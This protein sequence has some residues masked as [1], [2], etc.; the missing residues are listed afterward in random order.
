MRH[1]RLVSTIGAR[2]QRVAALGVFIALGLAGGGLAISAASAA[3]GAPVFAAAIDPGLPTGPDVSATSQDATFYDVTCTS[4]GDCVAVG[5]YLDGNGSDDRQAMV[6]TETNGTWARPTGIPSLPSGAATGAGQQGAFLDG[7]TCASAGDCTAVGGY[8]DTTGSGQAMV[9][10]ETNGVWAAAKKLTLPSGYN[11]TADDQSAYLSAV[12]C[13]GAGNC[14]A[15]GS[16]YD[17]TGDS[18]DQQ[19]MIATET[20]GTWASAKLALPG[21]A[22]PGSDVFHAGLNT[23]TCSGPGDCVAGGYYLDSNGPNDYQAML[24]KDTG[25]TWTAAKLALPT[26]AVTTPSGQSA[27][28]NSITCTSAG[29]CVGGGYYEDADTPHPDYQAMV[30]S[31]TNGTWAQPTEVT[32]PA[33]HTTNG[34]EDAAVISVACTAPGDCVAVGSYYDNNG[35]YDGQP[36]YL[37]QTAGVWTSA[38][39]ASLPADALTTPGNQDGQFRAVACTGLGTCV[40]VGNYSNLHGEYQPMI[41][42]SLPSLAVSTTSLPAAGVGS[43]YSAQL[44]ASG[45]SGHYTWSVSAGTLP[46]GLTLNTA[47][48]VIS[49]TPT[50]L[51]TA[52]ITVLASDP[53][54]PAQQASAALSIAVDGPSIGTVKSEAPELKISIT[55]GAIAPQSCSGTLALSVSEHLTGDKITA[56]VAKAKHKKPKHTTRTV[57]IGK[58]NYSVSGGSAATVAVTLNKAGKQLLAKYHKLHAK[59]ADTPTGLATALTTQTVTITPH[60]AKPKHKHH[61]K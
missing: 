35:T 4:P 38:T 8:T 7:L 25:G 10:T 18:D 51:G 30:A 20:S 42:D 1:G 56:I 15:V 3:T 21:D 60:K 31:E 46:A 23:V 2:C 12:T 41:A 13:T 19:A 59:L 34:D 32:I 14:I 50:A 33:N 45:G 55:C 43:A 61:R 9:V 48:G 26:G 53:G 28:L 36:M 49:G 40:A 39:E 16:Y 58:A 47:T 37:T 29:N 17:G 44:A 27:G 22:G 6:A 52:A 54:P 5:V 11:T 24:V 57:G